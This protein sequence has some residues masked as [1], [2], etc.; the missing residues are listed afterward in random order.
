MKKRH[1]KCICKVFSLK[2]LSLRNTDVSRLPRQIQELRLLETLDIRQTNVR[3]TDT[4]RIILPRLLKHLLAGR[5]IDCSSDDTRTMSKE[6][7]LSTVR[8]PRKI[9]RSMEILSH[10]EVSRHGK[11]ELEEVGSLRKLR[12]LGVVL[13][14]AVKKISNTFTEQST[15]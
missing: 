10:V 7:S 15:N 11:A 8:M 6:S 4:E 13:Q 2:Y 12:K 1:L 3:A 5:R 9:G 14:L